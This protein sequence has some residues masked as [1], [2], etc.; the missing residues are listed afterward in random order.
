MAKLLAGRRERKSSYY[1]VL[2]AVTASAS[3]QLVRSG[4]VSAIRSG[5]FHG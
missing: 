2:N 5:R 1:S 3:W 4:D